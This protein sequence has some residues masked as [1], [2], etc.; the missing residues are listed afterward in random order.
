MRQEFITKCDRVFLTKCDSYYKF[1]RFYYKMRQLLWNATFITN[2]DSTNTKTTSTLLTLNRLLTLS[3][4]F[5]CLLWT[6]KCRLGYFLWRFFFFSRTLWVQ[7][8][9]RELVFYINLFLESKSYIKGLFFNSSLL[10]LT[11]F[12]DAWMSKIEFKMSIWDLMQRFKCHG[13][14]CYVLNQY[15]SK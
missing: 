13:A 9:I 15:L 7:Q 1:R 10:L 8:F 4:C 5:H 14:S 11:R 2:C 3:W 12:N 6:S